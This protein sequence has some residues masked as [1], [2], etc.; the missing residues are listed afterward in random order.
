MLA[1]FCGARPTLDG[2]WE[3]PADASLGLVRLVRRG[4]SKDAALRPNSRDF[5]SELRRWLDDTEHTLIIR[6]TFR[7]GSEALFRRVHEVALGHGL[8]HIT[9]VRVSTAPLVY[10]SISS[11]RESIAGFLADPARAALLAQ[12]ETYAVDP[13]ELVTL[14]GRSSIVRDA[15]GI[16]MASTTL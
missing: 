2:A 3:P 16:P 15:H 9:V 14:E 5:T 6:R 10:L 11:Y 1:S 4:I 8:Q 7:V 12:L 13:G